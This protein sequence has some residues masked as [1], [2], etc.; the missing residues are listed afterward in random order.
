MSK[1]H[2]SVENPEIEI[3]KARV[4]VFYIWVAA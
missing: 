4:S 2:F 1:F 3:S